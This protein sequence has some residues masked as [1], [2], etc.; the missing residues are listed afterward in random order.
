MDDEAL[1]ELW[2]SALGC[3]AWRREDLLVAAATGGEPP[4]SLGERNAALLRWRQRLCGR[5]L[6][7]RASCPCCAAEL[8]F[9]LDTESL[10]GADAAP[11]APPAFDTLQHGEQRVTFRLPRSDDLRA[12]AHRHRDVEALEQALLERCVCTIDG[13]AP[14]GAGALSDELREAIAARMEALD[15]RA[16]LGCALLCPDCAH[17]WDAPLDVAALLWP[18]LRRRAERVLVDV[19]ALASAYGWS[20]T[21]VLRLNP[22][23][24]RAYLQLAGAA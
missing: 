17:R 18:E 22:A 15:P 24:R 12:L 21:D 5:A 16:S 2:E 13:D 7:L 6:P 11:A 4:Q 8:D 1:L 9:A 14:G 10:C 3:D 23:R 20:E 19:A